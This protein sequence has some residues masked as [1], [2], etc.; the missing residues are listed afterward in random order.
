[1]K[2]EDEVFVASSSP[3]LPSKLGSYIYNEVARI[4]EFVCITF[5]ERQK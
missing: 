2:S 3:H 1:M 5:G 4:I